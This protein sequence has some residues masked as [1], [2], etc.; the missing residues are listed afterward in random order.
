MRTKFT[1]KININSSHRIKLN[2]FQVKN[3][4]RPLLKLKTISFSRKEISNTNS[5]GR[6][7]IRANHTTP[8][9]VVSYIASLDLF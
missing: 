3:L 4:F 7:V 6:C 2:H 1:S 9:Y 5:K 8:T